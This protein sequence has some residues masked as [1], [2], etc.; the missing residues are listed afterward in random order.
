MAVLNGAGA[1]LVESGGDELPAVSSAEQVSFESWLDFDAVQFP[2]DIS[3]ADAAAYGPASPSIFPGT[4]IA[5]EVFSDAWRLA[6]SP[7]SPTQ[8]ENVQILA[9]YGAD[10]IVGG[11][12]NSPIRL[13]NLSL[14]LNSTMLDAHLARIYNTITAG[15]AAIFLDYDCNMYTG[16]YRYRFEAGDSQHLAHSTSLGEPSDQQGGS[17]P[18]SI[19]TLSAARSLYPEHSVKRK[20]GDT[21]SIPSHSTMPEDRGYKMTVLGAVCFLDHFGDLYGNMMSSTARRKSD[22][23]MRAV[24][25]VFSFQWLPATSVSC[26]FSPVT[27]QHVF[28]KVPEPVCQPYDGASHEFVEAWFRARRLVSNTQPLRSFGVVYATLLFDT[29]AIPGEV[30]EDASHN[31]R[32][33]E[34]L[35]DAL[36]KLL[37]LEALVKVYCTG[38][39]S[40]S[41]YGAL[42]ESS[43]NII[44]WFGYLR[45]TVAALTFA[46][47]CKLPDV[48]SRTSGERSLDIVDSTDGTHKGIP[49]SRNDD[50]GPLLTPSSGLGQYHDENVPKICRKAIAEA[51]H[52]WRGIIRK[53]GKSTNLWD[54]T[55]DP[56][57]Q[58][59]S[60][61]TVAMTAV[62][63]FEQS[64]RPFMDHCTESF[65]TLSATS[66][67]FAGLFFA[68]RLVQ[69]H[70]C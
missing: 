17:D 68:C 43:L 28:T 11:S 52:V 42:L 20:H 51:F 22:E 59:C 8:P 24:L 69:D 44:R 50:L 70:C 39:G 41:K 5:S 46:G 54:D 57:A 13:L 10:L 62:C 49:S 66:K 60:D 25:R 30:L 16:R 18:P 64:Y 1:D 45:D 40:A 38:L 55:M 32:Q 47:H 9:D 33:H 7:R 65:A 48:E 23:V 19:P 34:F 61:V 53:I 67:R 35:D 26:E 58:M 37:S 21:G 6:P 3:V 15:A 12:L 31:I 27:S 56:S 29:I 36:R 4:S 63:K 2:D 14:K